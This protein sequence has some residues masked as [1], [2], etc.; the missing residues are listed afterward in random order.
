MTTASDTEAPA[1]LP[2]PARLVLY[3]GECGLCHRSVRFLIRR[4][5]GRQLRYAPLAGETAA[6]ARARFPNF[7]KSI[8][9]LVF[10]DEG[11]VFVR[12][13]AVLRAAAYGGASFRVLAY[14]ARLLTPIADLA[15]RLV[16]R[17]RYRVFGRADACAVPA[18]GER[19]LFLP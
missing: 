7:P 12:S 6:R 15:Y 13:Q 4:D 19:A 10:I 1:D 9:T 8:D 14:L 16:A 17:T 5:S 18:P 3:D 2:L 11:R